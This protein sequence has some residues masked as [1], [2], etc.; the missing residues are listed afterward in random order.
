MSRTSNDATTPIVIGRAR[1][2]RR[3]KDMTP[4]LV[5]GEIAII[6][7]EDLDRVAAENLV[8]AKP[9]AIINGALS[10]SG[11]YPNV[12]P[13]LVAAAGIPLIDGV[14]KELLDRVATGAS[15]RI[16]GGK[17]YS[18]T[19]LVGEGTV[20]SMQLLE[21]AYEQAKTTIG[22][23][24]ERFAENTLEY[25][26]RERHLLVDAPDFPDLGVDFRNR[27]VLIVV[28]G[29]DYRSDLQALGSYIREMRPI[30]IAVDG[31]ADALVEQGHKPDIIVGDFDS[32]SDE[33]LRRGA[34]L[35][36]HAFVDGRAPGAARLEDLG[37]AHHKVP[38]PG[39]SEDIAMLLAYE[40]GAELI[41]A[42]GTH[43]SMV[44]FL[45]KG[46]PGMASTFLVRLKVGPILMDAKGVSRLYNRRIR[47]RDMSVFLF[48]VLVAFLV[49]GF[50][51]RHFF[52][53]A[54]G[55]LWDSVFR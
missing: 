41:V 27:Q 49:A 23:E 42:V 19:E 31:G 33:T 55:L 26:V 24:L 2:G 43:A 44:D 6:H 5:L 18:G 51:V 36:V 13:L 22:V 50:S 48:S 11:R 40:N 3:T 39:T 45:D 1:I 21:E 30:I 47:K 20:Q 7:H 8:E 12:G 10:M 29:A 4:Q 14:G 53:E 38:F 16:E 35:V 9:A 54:F 28:R 32:V 25:M 34:R 17:I 37:L 15:I 46:R 52:G